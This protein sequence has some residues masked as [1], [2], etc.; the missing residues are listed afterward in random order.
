MVIM[1]TIF[2]FHL[3]RIITINNVNRIQIQ[4][5][6]LKLNTGNYRDEKIKKI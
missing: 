3:N 2:K 6:K 4:Q 5:Y 1:K